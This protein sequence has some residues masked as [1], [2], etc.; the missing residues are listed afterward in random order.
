MS[1]SAGAFSGLK[2]I[3]ENSASTS[4]KLDKFIDSNVSSS[5]GIDSATVGPGGGAR[6]QGAANFKAEVGT[7]GEFKS[8]IEF[9]GG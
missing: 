5:V 6:L 1:A 3:S 9:D 4:L 7:A 2:T 8:A